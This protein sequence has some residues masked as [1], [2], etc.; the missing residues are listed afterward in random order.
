MTVDVGKGFTLPSGPNS[1]N[2]DKEEFMK[3]DFEV[4]VYSGLQ[5]K[6]CP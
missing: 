2:F 4:E 1:L 6:G 3:K 5:K